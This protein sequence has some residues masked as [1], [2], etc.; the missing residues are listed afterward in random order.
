MSEMET[1]TPDNSNDPYATM[2]PDLNG[3]S[4]A[5][6]KRLNSMKREN[7]TVDEQSRYLK[8]K[9]SIESYKVRQML[10]HY[11]TR[12][13]RQTTHSND[14]R[15]K[16]KEPKKKAIDPPP[17]TSN[18]DRCRH[19]KEIQKDVKLMTGR[20]T[21]LEHCISSEKE[22]PDLTDNA[23]LV[24]YQNEY[25]DLTSLKEQKLGELALVLPCPVL[26]CPENEIN[27]SKL[28]DP[29]KN[30]AKKHSRKKLKLIDPIAGTNQPINVKNKFSSF[31]GKEAKIISPISNQATA[32]VATPKIPPIM[33]KHKKENYKNI[34]EDL[35]KDS[36][37]CN[38]KLSGKYLKIFTTNSDEHRTITDYLD[39]KREEFYV[40]EPL[41]SRP[42]KVVSKGLPISTQI[43]EIQADLTSQGFCIEKVHQIE[44]KIP[45]PH[46]YGRAQ[47][48][49]RIPR[50][51]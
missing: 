14:K 9:D 1:E 17:K 37:N 42:Q 31:A 39:E 51:F 10:A 3:E 38:V 15:R 50:H 16:Q 44:N 7:M 20:L 11:E 46:F 22:F 48:I 43:G 6:Y 8:L 4:M 13:T 40:I 29:R 2:S 12:Y 24:G 25:D 30:N 47:K 32:P 5:E 26:D 34:I 35:N 45:A 33:F 19:H 28:N 49:I 41:D 21:F 36:P 23:I 18:H 27:S